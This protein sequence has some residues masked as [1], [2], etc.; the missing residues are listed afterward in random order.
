MDVDDDDDLEITGESGFN[1]A[2][3]AP[4]ARGDCLHCKLSITPH[5]DTCSLC[6]CFVC[7]ELASTCTHWF[8]ACAASDCKDPLKQCDSHCHATKDEARW[9]TA[10][11]K[12]KRDEQSR[13]AAAQRAAAAARANAQQPPNARS[14]AAGQAAMGAAT[15]A[16]ALPAAPPAPTASAPDP[17]TAPAPPTAPGAVA[18]SEADGER[19]MTGANEEAE[20]L[21]QEYRPRHWALGC[22]HPDPVVETTSLAFVAPPVLPN[23]ASLLP[24]ICDVAV[25]SGALSALQLE[26]VAYACR[27]HEQTLGG[28]AVPTPIAQTHRLSLA[29]CPTLAFPLGLSP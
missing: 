10:R 24:G 25:S 7:D 8:S 2:R 21:F 22:D 13:Q 3:D 29:P 4:H 26:A 14:A 6:Y 5:K 11:A 23:Q 15:V 1:A 12:A 27:R 18:Q 28:P 9:V 17:A 20:D 16:P 19:A